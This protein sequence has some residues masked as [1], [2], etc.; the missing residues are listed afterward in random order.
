MHMAVCMFYV[1]LS[2]CGRT[3]DLCCL[4]ASIKLTCFR[5]LVEQWCSAVL[6]TGSL[7]SWLGGDTHTHGQQ[8]WQ[9]HLSCLL[10]LHF[11]IPFQVY[12]RMFILPLL[13]VGSPCARHLLNVHCVFV[14]S[15][16]CVPWLVSLP[17]PHIGPDV[18]S[19]QCQI[20]QNAFLFSPSPAAFHSYFFT[21]LEPIGSPTHFFFLFWSLGWHL[22]ILSQPEL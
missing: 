21:I 11:L 14:W 13:L 5:M 4:C 15:H 2:E 22:T 20:S 16:N 19:R 18:L 7:T 9:V 1:W 12:E 8:C 3:C 17:V 6:N 10:L